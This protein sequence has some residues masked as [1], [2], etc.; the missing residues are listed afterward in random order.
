MIDLLQTKMN[1]PI[2]M[3][4]TQKQ[5]KKSKIANLIVM[6][7]IASAIFLAGPAFAA[8]P[9]YGAESISM[10]TTTQESMPNTKKGITGTVASVSGSIL[11]VVST[12]NMEYTVDASHATIMKAA[13]EV[14]ENPLIVNVSDIKVG[15]A[16]AA[17]GVVREE[18]D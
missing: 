16:I 6:P 8:G 15:D 5:S 3:K 12:D 1:T 13:G 17:R 4:K 9:S 10:N 14:N 7:L 11:H 2:H 18:N